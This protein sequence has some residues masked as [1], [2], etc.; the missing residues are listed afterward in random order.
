LDKIKNR[1]ED[2]EAKNELSRSIKLEDMASKYRLSKRNSANKERLSKRHSAQKERLSAH[3]K[4]KTIDIFNVRK[5]NP[6]KFEELFL[7]ITKYV[8]ERKEKNPF[9]GPSPYH[10]FYKER[11]IKI[12]KKIIQMASGDIDT[13]FEIKL[14]V[15]EKNE[16]EIKEEESNKE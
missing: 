2:L 1:G 8:R 14:E 13:N 10:E 7:D 6:I 12:K 5:I 4:N 11:R 9:E 15:N 3:Q 16:N